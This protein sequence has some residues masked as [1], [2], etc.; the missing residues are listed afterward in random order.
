MELPVLE[1]PLFVFPHGLQ[2]LA[3]VNNAF[4]LPL[5][6]TL[7]FTDPSGDQ[8]YAACLQFYEE[9]EES[10]L[11]DLCRELYKLP[12]EE[13]LVEKGNEEKS[14]LGIK[15]NIMNN[16][17]TNSSSSTNG[18]VEGDG[19]VE[20]ENEN[21]NELINENELNEV[22][23]EETTAQQAIISRLQSPKNVASTVSSDICLTLPP[24]KIYAP[25]VICVLSK[26]PFYRLI[27]A[28][29]CL[30]VLLVISYYH[31]DYSVFI[32]V[33]IFMLIIIYIL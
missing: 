9:V 14:D 31:Y 5:F 26:M 32:L 11:I 10:E 15:G 17:N 12:T 27:L 13:S 33:F 4:P 7:L 18:E 16:N 23:L 22:S 28:K 19:M 20:N 21:E 1:L 2:L 24:E 25:K 29:M 3:S 30:F 6:F 8:Y